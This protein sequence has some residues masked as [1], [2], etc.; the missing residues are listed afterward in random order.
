MRPWNLI[1][2]VERPLETVDA[3]IISVNPARPDEVVWSAR[4]DPAAI[5]AAV[6][7]ARAALDGWRMAGQEARASALKRLAAVFTARAEDIAR[8]ITAE[9]GKTLAESRLEAK[10]L[11][12]KVAITLGETCQARVRPWDVQVAPTRTGR[13]SFRSHGVMA[14]LGPF[15][16]PAHLPNGH[17]VPALLLGNTIVFKPSERTPL[18]GQLMAECMRAAELPPGVFNLVQGGPAVAKALVAHE[19]LDGI[20]FTGSW[21]VGRSIMQANL[22]RPGRLLALEMGGSNAAIVLDDAHRRQAVLECVRASF[23]TA[24]PHPGSCRPSVAWPARC[25]WVMVMAVR[26]PSWDRWR[27]SGH[28]MQRWRFRPMQSGVAPRCCCAPRPWTDRG[29]SSRRGC[30]SGLA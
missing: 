5:D 28:A 6:A 22:D 16:F 27:P 7:S 13:C 4:A 9:M 30:C 23:A 25:S 24:M 10:L 20:L 21:P 14:V 17:W 1:G 11:A 12:D 19:G 18:V 3:D 2:G 8:A 26:R 29:G 15:N